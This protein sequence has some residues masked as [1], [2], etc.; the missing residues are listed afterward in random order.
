[1]GGPVGRGWRVLLEENGRGR[2]F[3]RNRR[4]RKG[5][6]ERG[7]RVFGSNGRTHVSV[8]RARLL[9]REAESARDARRA[10]E[11]ERERTAA[12]R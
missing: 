12:L 1:M 4:R 3:G 6:R 9:A 10:R 2:G 7:G 11:R 8:T 5:F